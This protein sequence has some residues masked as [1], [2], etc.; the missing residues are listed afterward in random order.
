MKGDAR[1]I[2]I[3]K[4]RRREVRKASGRAYIINGRPRGFCRKNRASFQ[5][6]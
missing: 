5:K 3:K 6:K 4:A 1:K 2:P